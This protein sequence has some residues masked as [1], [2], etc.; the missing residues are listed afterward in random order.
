MS[1][2]YA[3]VNLVTCTAVAPTFV[4]IGLL[5]LLRFKE[6]GELRISNVNEE[7]QVR[8]W[9]FWALLAELGFAIIV[10]SIPIGLATGVIQP[11]EAVSIEVGR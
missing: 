6:T 1:D 5:A 7:A 9:K 2:F 10:L 8:V 4:T 3:D 11:P